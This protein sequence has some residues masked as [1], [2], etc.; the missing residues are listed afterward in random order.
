MHVVMHRLRL[1]PAPGLRR[2][3]ASALPLAQSALAA[4]LAWELA[5]R[6]PH[7]QRP[8]FAPIAAVL[9]LGVALG[10]RSQRAVEVSL[11][12][13]V[14]VLV[15]DVLVNWVGVGT[16]QITCG[17]ALAMVTAV[18]MGGSV[19]VIN[20]A[21]ASAVLITALPLSFSGRFYYRF[22][23][24][25]VGGAVAVVVNLILLP[26]D[27]LAVVA[28]SKRPLFE[29]VVAEL[30][31][32]ADALE[33]GSAALATDALMRLRDAE[34]LLRDFQAAVE[35]GRETARL[36]P[37]RRRSKM[38]LSTLTDAG[39]QLD[40]IVRNQR[41]MIRRIVRLLTDSPVPVAE[42]A[43]SMQL[44]ASAIRS[45]ESELNGASDF[46]QSRAFA[47]EAVDA[48]GSVPV[49]APSASLTIVIGQIRSIAVDLLRATGLAEDEALDAVRMYDT[50]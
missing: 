7:H 35:A 8:Y 48:A 49:G 15:G 2:V 16:W 22:E 38:H 46:T 10:Q 19:L 11:G 9:S 5:R 21:A 27:P 39:V 47:L 3:R 33:Q 32:C 37:L 45:L 6:I 26:L 23:D 34:P 36:A 30:V 28:R 31:S 1:D 18:F 42:L 50:P 24:A 29:A 25:V 40:R 41:V 4:G 43:T 44:L 20:Q 14:G 12:V 13:A 17:V